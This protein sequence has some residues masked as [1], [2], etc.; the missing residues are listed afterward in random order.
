MKTRHAVA[1]V[2]LVVLAVGAVLAFAQFDDAGN[3]AKHLKKLDYQVE[4]ADEK[5]FATHDIELDLSVAEYRDGY[6][7]RTWCETSDESERTL[8]KLCNKLNHEATV[9]R[10]YVDNEGDL[11]F[12]AWYPGEYDRDQF[13]I[14]MEAWQN[15]TSGQYSTIV[16]ALGL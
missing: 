6:L 2:A 4:K 5:L 12:E 1:L 8:R 13:D 16:D 7:I 14:F 15:D 9:A 3:V 10:F 11:I